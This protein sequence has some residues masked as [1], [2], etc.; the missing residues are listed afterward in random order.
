LNLS[1]NYITHIDDLERLLE[2]PSLKKLSFKGNKL[3]ITPGVTGHEGNEE[4]GVEAGLM[5][6]YI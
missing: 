3:I 5:I 4:E 1:F 6:L 2:I